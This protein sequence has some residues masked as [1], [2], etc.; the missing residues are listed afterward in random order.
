MKIRHGHVSNSSSS[1]FII[2]LKDLSYEQIGKIVSHREVVESCFS[3]NQDI[4]FRYPKDSE[5]SDYDVWKIEISKDEIKGFT[6]MDNLSMRDFLPA[7]G[8]DS[9]K[10]N[11]IE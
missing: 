8:V 5:F 6:A 3:K 2:K 4:Y 1:S 9:E 10:I 7:I 11:W